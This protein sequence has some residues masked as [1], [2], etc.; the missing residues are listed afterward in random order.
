MTHQINRSALA[1]LVALAA[2][3]F[4]APG[5]AAPPAANGAPPTAVAPAGTVLIGGFEGKTTANKQYG[6]LVMRHG[7]EFGW[8]WS[9]TSDER[10]GG[11]SSAGI[12]IV[13]P[14]ADDTHGALEVSGEIKAGFLA[15]WAGAIWFPGNYPTQPAD[16]S[17]SKELSFWARGTPGSY[18]LMLSTGSAESMPLYSAFVIGKQWKEY[19]IPLAASFPNADWKKVVY[20]AFSA[21]TTGKFQ[22]ELDQVTLH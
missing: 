9:T 6:T 12:T 5:F 14:G 1:G 7:K 11:H 2:L 16:L 21:A 13:H 17:A 18:N 3:A 10:M 20:L 15:P 19:R 8:G 22:F 4:A